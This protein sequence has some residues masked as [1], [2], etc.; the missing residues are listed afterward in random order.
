M[1]MPIGSHK[2]WYAVE[3]N[4]DP[5]P[6]EKVFDVSCAVQSSCAIEIGISNPTSDD[7]TFQI[8]IINSQCLS[9]ANSLHLSAN[10][11]TKFQIIYS[12]TIIG[13]F[14]ARYGYFAGLK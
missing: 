6:P 2:V 10:E 8:Q 4:A 5:A 1:D 3:I 12:P 7:I 9:G 13:T 14:N 11:S